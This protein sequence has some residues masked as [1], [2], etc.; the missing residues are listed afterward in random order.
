[1]ATADHVKALV[2]SHAAGDEERFYAVA[3]QVA[4]QAARQGH[5]AIRERPSHF[6]R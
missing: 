2:Q 1:M 3:M 6:G 4:A 5:V